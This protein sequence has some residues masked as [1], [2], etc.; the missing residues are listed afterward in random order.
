MFPWKGLNNVCSFRRVLFPVWLNWHQE[1][2]SDQCW[3][4][5]QSLHKGTE[6]T[7]SIF[8]IR[9]GKN[10]LNCLIGVGISL[11]ETIPVEGTSETVPMSPIHQTFSVLFLAVSRRWCCAPGS[12]TMPCWSRGRRQQPTRAQHWSG[13]RSC[14]HS[15]WRLC[16]RS[17]RN[18]P[19]LKVCVMM[20]GTPTDSPAMEK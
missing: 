10:D 17:S 5:L 14:V 8:S 9:I 4:I 2:L 1:H 16:S 11:D 3:V 12:I 19:M 18:T 20:A 7:F 6:A 15:H 13:W